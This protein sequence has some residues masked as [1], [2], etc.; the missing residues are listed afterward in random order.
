MATMGRFIND[1]RSLDVVGK[2]LGTEDRFE[3]DRFD[4]RSFE[5]IERLNLR[6]NAVLAAPTETR[7]S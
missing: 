5:I 4:Q 1:K 2:V 7:T 3:V 6:F